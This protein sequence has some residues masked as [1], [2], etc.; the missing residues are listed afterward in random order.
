VHAA[1]TA[2]KTKIFRFKIL[3]REFPDDSKQRGLSA[4]RRVHAAR[5]SAVKD[6]GRATC[7][8][9]TAD[10]GSESAKTRM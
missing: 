9:A 5:T 4:A 8:S 10:A 6:R 7:A 1:R 3:F 2:A